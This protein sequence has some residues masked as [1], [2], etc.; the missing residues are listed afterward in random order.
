M[1]PKLQLTSGTLCSAQFIV[2][3]Q[4]PISLVIPKLRELTGIF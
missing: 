3:R 1:G 4:R 2:E